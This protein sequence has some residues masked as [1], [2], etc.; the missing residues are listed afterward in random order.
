MSLKAFKRVTL[1]VASLAPEA[2]VR[3]FLALQENV[4][5]FLDRLAQVPQLDSVRIA[6][7]TLTGG[8]DVAVNHKLGRAVQDWRFLSPKTAATVYE[9]SK[10][11]KVITLH[12][13]ATVTGNLEVW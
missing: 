9:V 12:A 5:A 11:D 7:V 6:G 8:A 2:S 3:L 13:S 1:T 10:D 4:G